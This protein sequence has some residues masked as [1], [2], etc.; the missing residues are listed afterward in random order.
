MVS[1][2]QYS[3]SA[4]FRRAGRKTGH[5]PHK[6]MEQGGEFTHCSLMHKWQ[7]HFC[8]I[9]QVITLCRLQMLGL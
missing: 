3:Q 9:E 8:T 5:Q 7:G 2:L 6:K 4:A 1:S